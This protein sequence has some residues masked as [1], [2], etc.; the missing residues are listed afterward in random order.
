[1][2]EGPQL[3][4]SK[5]G[6]LNPYLSGIRASTH[7][8][9]SV[10]CWTWEHPSVFSLSSLHKKCIRIIVLIPTS[11]ALALTYLVSVLTNSFLLDSSFPLMS[12]SYSNLTCHKLI[13]FSNQLSISI[14]LF[15]SVN[16]HSQAPTFRI[17]TNYSL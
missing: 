11:L 12:P 3:I 17:L 13:F 6:V 5:S 7:N 1:M 8:R 15:L 16:L 14:C 4:V 2:F 9:L 10:P